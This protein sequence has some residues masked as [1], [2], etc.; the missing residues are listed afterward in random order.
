MAVKISGIL[1]S[2]ELAVNGQNIERC[3]FDV[4]DDF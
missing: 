4:K 3:R 2:D 1:E